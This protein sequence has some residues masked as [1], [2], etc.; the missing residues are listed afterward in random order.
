MPLLNEMKRLVTCADEPNP[1]GHRQTT[2]HA[3]HTTDPSDLVDL[4]CE[5]RT[6]LDTEMIVEQRLMIG[7]SVDAVLVVVK[8]LNAIEIVV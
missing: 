6:D 5:Q 1:H 7:R 2:E 3:H 8:V 4:I